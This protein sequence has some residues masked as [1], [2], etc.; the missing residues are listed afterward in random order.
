ME[1]EYSKRYVYA[2][3]TER[4]TNRNPYEEKRKLIELLHN[5]INPNSSNPY[6]EG[7]LQC[8]YLY[9]VIIGG[10]LSSSTRDGFPM[11]MQYDVD[12]GLIE[13]FILSLPEVPVTE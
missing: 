8:I 6:T 9:H 4:A 5:S 11:D 13:K 7:E 3:K 2:G 12:G 10:S 1:E